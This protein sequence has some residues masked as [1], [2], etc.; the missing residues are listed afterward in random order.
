MFPDAP[1]GSADAAKLLFSN[2]DNPP[3]HRVNGHNRINGTIRYS[4][5]NG[6]IWSTS[7][8]FAPGLPTAYSTVGPLG[9]GRYC[10]LYEGDHNTITFDTFDAQWLGPLCG[11]LSA[12]AASVAPGGTAD[13]TFT[14]TKLATVTVR[15]TAPVSANVS[16]VTGRAEFNAAQGHLNVKVPVTVT[17]AS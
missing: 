6:A 12:G 8:A 5:D 11:T 16:T 9:N 10:V 2:A 3:S 4:C 14:V 13:V 15:V 1:E 7:R 17:P